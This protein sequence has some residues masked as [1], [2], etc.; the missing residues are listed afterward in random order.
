MH[1]KLPRDSSESLETSRDGDSRLIPVDFDPTKLETRAL[2]F[3]KFRKVTN[4]TI[5][6]V[7]QAQL[8]AKDDVIEQL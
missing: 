1:A 8:K 3:K 5:T 6:L 2:N 7:A 4:E